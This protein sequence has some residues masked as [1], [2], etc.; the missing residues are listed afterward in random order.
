MFCRKEFQKKKIHTQQLANTICKTRFLNLF[1]VYK[2]ILS[3]ISIAKH[4]SDPYSNDCT[5]F[6]FLFWSV[7]C[8]LYRAFTKVCCFKKNKWPAT[9]SVAYLN[10]ST[11]L[12]P[13]SVDFRLF[14]RAFQL[15]FCIQC[16]MYNVQCYSI[17]RSSPSV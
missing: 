8:S 2:M 15:I 4:T 10:Y 12:W 17:R 16:T 3:K 5:W 11:T 7:P 13:K 1:W 14:L 6:L 9:D